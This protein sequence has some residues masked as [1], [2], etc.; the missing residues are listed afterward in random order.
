MKKKKELHFYGVALTILA[1]FD[2]CMLLIGFLRGDYAM[3]THE[4][5]LV[6]AVT[7]GIVIVV[8]GC[9]ALSVLGGA[10]LGVKGIMESKKPSGGRLHIVIAKFAMVLNF[11]LAGFMALTLFGTDN[12]FDDFTTT[13]LCVVDAM[14]MYCYMKAAI[15]VRNG[16]E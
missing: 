12:F 13:G 14:F 4:D 7:N 3:V 10:Y 9:A 16:E 6:Q 5:A 8:V 15:A 2:L 11:V 1:L